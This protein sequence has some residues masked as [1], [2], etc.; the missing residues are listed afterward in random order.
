VNSWHILTSE[1]PPD[2]GGVS[3]YTRQVAEALVAAGDDVHV[4]CPRQ[5]GESGSRVVQ[6]HGEMG[7]IGPADLRRLDRCLN[8]HEAPRRLLVQWVP[9]GFGYRS[10]N[11]WFCLWL[12]TRAWRGD[13]VQLMVHE[14]YVEFSGPLRYRAMAAVHRL[15]TIVL[16]AAS[17]QVWMSIPAW[18]ARLRPYALGRRLRMEWLPVPG[19]AEPTA[20][21]PPM[22]RREYA[23]DWRPVIGHFGSYG[24]EVSSLLEERLAAILEHESTPSVLLIGAGGDTL[25]QTLVRRNAEWTSR[26]HATGFVAP[27]DLSGVIGLCDLFVQPY[28]D[29]ISSRRTSAMSCLAAGRPVV[30]TRGHLTEPLW[31]DSGAV[32]LA[33]VCDVR[34][35]VTSIERLLANPDERRRLG[36]EGRR[37]YETHFS[38]DRLVSTLRAA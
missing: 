13:H 7:G 3:E 23:T 24:R 36:D 2:I 9:H 11:L 10:M 14:P 29:G 35:F 34:S 4:W 5:A 31:D 6:V 16:L 15:M 33:D 30:T 37:L 19:S 12:A 21:P 32:V 26:V 1:Y 8:E 18:E 17:R 25:R 27:A 38:V 20:T 22:Q 28:P